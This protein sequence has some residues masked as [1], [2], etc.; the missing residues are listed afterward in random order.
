MFAIVMAALYN[1][2]AGENWLSVPSSLL[3]QSRE[4]RS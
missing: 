3:H 2:Y 4:N 1:D